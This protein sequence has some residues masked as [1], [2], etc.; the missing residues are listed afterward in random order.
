M[1]GGAEMARRLVDRE[2]DV[3]QRPTRGAGKRDLEARD[4]LKQSRAKRRLEAFVRFA[5]LRK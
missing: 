1:H 4:N 2:S 5:A 3:E